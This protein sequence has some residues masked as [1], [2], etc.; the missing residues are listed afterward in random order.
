M[1]YRAS[2]GCRVKPPTMDAQKLA[3]ALK[4]HP[5]ELGVHAS[6]W[7]IRPQFRCHIYEEVTSTNTELWRRLD[8]GATSGTVVLAVRQRSGRGQRGHQWQSPAGGLYL[9]LALEPD[10]PLTLSS[11]FTL[12]SAW[13]VASS[14]SNLSLPVRLKWPNDL[15]VAQQKLGGILTETRVEAGKIRAVVIG[16][17][18]NWVNPVPVGGIS[19]Q[20]LCPEGLSYPLNTVENLAAVVLYGLIQGYIYWQSQG[21]DALLA[22]YCNQLVNL[23]QMVSVNGHLN[24]VTGITPE[25]RI[26]LRPHCPEGELAA[27]LE[28]EPG[29]ISLGY[30]T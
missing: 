14:L 6:G 11:Q 29:E 3:Q 13:G 2:L 26:Q 19:L 4:T 12:A 18:L 1:S 17:G 23:G 28:L 9:S 22:A 24:Q 20:Q 21:T 27:V 25:G 16:I 8:Q 5:K 15:V 10:L 30:N 7:G